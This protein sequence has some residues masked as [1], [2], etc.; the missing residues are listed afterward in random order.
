MSTAMKHLIKMTTKVIIQMILVIMVK[1]AMV[2]M[3]LPGTCLCLLCL[4]ITE[5]FIHKTLDLMKNLMSL[6]LVVPLV[7]PVRI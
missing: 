1:L 3:V 4:P 7:L 6:I 5:P 2:A